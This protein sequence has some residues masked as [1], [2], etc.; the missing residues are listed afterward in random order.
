MQREKLAII[1]MFTTDVVLILIHFLGLFHLRRGRGIGMFGLGRLLWK[2][3]RSW[4]F[5]GAMLLLAP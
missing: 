5:L 2:Q 3:V 1:A 4:Q